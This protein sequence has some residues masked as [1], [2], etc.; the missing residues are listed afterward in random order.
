MMPARL[1][2]AAAAAQETMQMT[3]STEVQAK[4]RAGY[5][6]AGYRGAG[7]REAEYRRA[8]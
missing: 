4:R 8:G 1:P 5:R 2:C 3:D 6:G 7:Y